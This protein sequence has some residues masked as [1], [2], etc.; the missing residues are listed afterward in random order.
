L[1]SQ[2]RLQVHNSNWRTHASKQLDHQRIGSWRVELIDASGNQLA[3]RNF[4]V[5]EN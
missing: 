4:T 1:D 5:T 2:L 3:I